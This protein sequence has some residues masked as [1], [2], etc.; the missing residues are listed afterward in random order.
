MPLLF[1][2]ASASTAIPAFFAEYYCYPDGTVRPDSQG[3]FFNSLTPGRCSNFKSVISE[4]IL[5]I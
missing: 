5:Q 3:K 2:Q 4:H 1:F